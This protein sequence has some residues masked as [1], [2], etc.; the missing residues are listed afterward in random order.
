[1]ELGEWLRNLGL[2]RYEAPFRD[3]AI[4]M[5]VLADLTE[6]DLSQ[7]GVALGDRKRLRK[8]IAGLI[9]HPFPTLTAPAPRPARD[10]A[11][12]RPITVMFCDLVGSTELATRLDAE[13]WRDLRRRLSRRGL[14]R[15]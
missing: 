3:Q 4:D 8:A 11:E 2:E 5:D 7:L 9:L 1:M 6:H 15:P 14:A 10:E 12:R 13:D